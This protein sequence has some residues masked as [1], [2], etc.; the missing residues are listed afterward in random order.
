MKL[1][2]YWSEGVVW[3]YGASFGICQIQQVPVEL[4][5]GTQ[6][7]SVPFV[8]ASELHKVLLLFLSLG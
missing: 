3:K 1:K 7:Q 6:S 5:S 8:C 4:L 2:K